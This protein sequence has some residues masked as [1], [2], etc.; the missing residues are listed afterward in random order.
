A[1]L[2]QIRS[3]LVQGKSHPAFDSAQGHP[4]ELCDLSLGEPTEVRKQNRVPLFLRQLGERGRDRCPL[5][6]AHSLVLGAG[7]G[8]LDF[9]AQRQLA[10]LVEGATAEQV[11]SPVSNGPTSQDLSV[12]L[13]ASKPDAP[14]Q[15]LR[16]ASWTTSSA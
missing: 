4:G 2:P 13:V 3:E 14:R 7:L 11:D 8:G 6:R 10:T 16:N 9:R 1:S 12:P 15:T 5:L